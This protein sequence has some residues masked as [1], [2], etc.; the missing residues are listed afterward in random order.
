MRGTV[1]TSF[2]FAKQPKRIRQ[3]SSG[4]LHGNIAALHIRMVRN[5]TACF[6]LH[7]QHIIAIPS[8]LVQHCLKWSSVCSLSL[9]FGSAFMCWNLLTA[10]HIR[11]GLECRCFN[12][13]TSTTNIWM[14][15]S[16]TP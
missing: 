6:M 3:V 1:Y 4:T 7:P 9:P 5:S 11:V 14:M 15:S 16:S 10:A 12:K 8:C 13:C 2:I